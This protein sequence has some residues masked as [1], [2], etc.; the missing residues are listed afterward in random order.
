M[1]NSHRFADIHKTAITKTNCYAL[2]VMPISE[3]YFYTFIRNKNG[4]E[5]WIYQTMERK[6]KQE[7]KTFQIKPVNFSRLVSSP[8]CAH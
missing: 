3:I 2:A 6:I 7:K 8:A 1:K 5:R 4:E